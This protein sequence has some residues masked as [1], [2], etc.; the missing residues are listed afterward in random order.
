MPDRKSENMP[1]SMSEYLPEKMSETIKIYD[2]CQDVYNIYI[3][4][5]VGEHI[6]YIR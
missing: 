6:K 2:V 4:A 1:D 3:C 5:T